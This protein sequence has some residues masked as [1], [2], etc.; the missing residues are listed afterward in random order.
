MGQIDRIAED[1]IMALSDFFGIEGRPRAFCVFPL[2][3]IFRDK[4]RKRFGFVYQPPHYIEN[5]ED[6]STLG[7]QIANLRKPRSLLGKLMSDSRMEGR[8]IW[9]L[10]DR[11]QLARN[12]AQCLYVLHAAGWVHK[13]Y[14][15]KST[16]CWSAKAPFGSHSFTAS[17]PLRSYFFHL[18]QALVVSLQRMVPK[19]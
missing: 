3:G 13:K 2:L 6:R 18:S 4:S 1:D 7:G 17:G 11:F 15:M 19:I 12:L 16:I 10:G 14:V 5:L 9:P 8:S